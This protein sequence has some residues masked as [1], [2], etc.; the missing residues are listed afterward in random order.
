MF[1]LGNIKLYVPIKNMGLVKFAKA[2]PVLSVRT[3]SGFC[4]FWGGGCHVGIVDRHKEKKEK[5]EKEGEEEKEE[6]VGKRQFRRRKRR[7]NGNEH[8]M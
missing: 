6:D 1:G 3:K 7:Y 2:G 8:E 5:E 4:A